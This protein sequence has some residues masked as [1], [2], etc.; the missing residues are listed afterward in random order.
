MS[1]K[2]GF[3]KDLKL[4]MMLETNIVRME[5]MC[6]KYGENHQEVSLCLR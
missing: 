5:F 6:Q 4:S 2:S 1:K 3:V